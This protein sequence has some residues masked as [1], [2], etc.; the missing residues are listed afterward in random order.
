MWM[1]GLFA[2]TIIIVVGHGHR[3]NPGQTVIVAPISDNLFPP[4]VPRIQIGLVAVVLLSQVGH[5]P[6]IH[7][8][9]VQCRPTE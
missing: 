5:G 7:C 9:I 8:V 1:A 6:N 3:L 2:L 4:S